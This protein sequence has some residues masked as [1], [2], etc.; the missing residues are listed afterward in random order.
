M[1]SLVCESCDG[2][3]V[4]CRTNLDTGVFEE[5]PC[6]CSSFEAWKIFETLGLKKKA[7][8]A[9]DVE[10]RKENSRIKKESLVLDS[11]NSNK[12]YEYKGGEL[13]KTVSLI[14]REFE[15]KKASKTTD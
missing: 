12:K 11:G 1:E 15:N 6:R 2:F 5:V 10:V 14:A 9:R 7:A 3:G 4:V 8:K 13:F